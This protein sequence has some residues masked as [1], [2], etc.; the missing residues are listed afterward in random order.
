MERGQDGRE[1]RDVVGGDQDQSVVTAQP[2]PAVGGAHVTH[3]RGELGVGQLAVA[4]L[5]REMV[6]ST[7]VEASVKEV[8]RRVELLGHGLRPACSRSCRAARS[9]S[10]A[11]RP[12]GQ[13][14]WAG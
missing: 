12:P 2:E 3:Q 5:D 6:A 13:R 11:G 7:L 8:L 14:R 4:A 9:R 1:H 10:D